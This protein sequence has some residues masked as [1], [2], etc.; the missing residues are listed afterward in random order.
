MRVPRAR[1]VLAVLGVTLAAAAHLAA[2]DL[3]RTRIHLVFEPDGAFVLDIAND[4]EWLLLR[5]EPFLEDYPDLPQR[6]ET[7][8][9][10]A[11]DRDARLALLA[12]VM[13]DRIV[14]FVDGREARA[15]SWEYVP[16][17]SPTEADGTPMAGHYVLRGRLAPDAR[18]LRWFYGIVADPYPL[19][20]ARAD[21][22][23]YTEW[24]GGT[25]WSRPID[26]T[27]QFV[28]PT[29]WEVVRQYVA[30]GFTHILPKG[31]DHILFVLSLF[32][33]STHLRPVLWQVT[34][35]TVAHSITLGLSV[36]GVVSLPPR[37]VE[38]LI[39]V[40]IAYVAIENLLTRHLYP[41]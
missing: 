8:R 22:E 18:L 38:P 13:T 2:H 5:L 23:V 21:G 9:L 1:L 3:E 14:L 16:P 19:V 7:A 10:T 24:I 15:Q 29:R 39:A 37:V 27:G 6:S 30:L 40:S 25:V 32:L 20:I 33:L 4:P 11:A 12:P 17:A 31:L 28:P 26:L 36:Y 41:W 35:F 34:A